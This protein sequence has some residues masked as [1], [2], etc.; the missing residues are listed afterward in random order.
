MA[1]L[2]E[3]LLA[4]VQGALQAAAPLGG[5]GGVLATSVFRMREASITRDLTP[6]IVV[7]PVQAD[8]SRY[9]AGVDKVQLE[10]AIEIFV[11]GDPWVSLADPIDVAAHAALMSDQP[12]AS[13]IADL[14]RIGEG[15]EAQEAD[16]TAGTLTVNYRAVFLTQAGAIDR[17]G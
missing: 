13:M 10:F 15:F 12:L 7:Q 5:D 4:R 8:F 14:R 1:S 17:A 2:R 6:A 11:R 16:R 3:Q 9:S